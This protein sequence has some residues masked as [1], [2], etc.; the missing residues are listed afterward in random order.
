[1]TRAR[2]E[3]FRVDPNDF[4]ARRTELVRE[5]RARGEKNEAAEVKA[6]RRPTVPVWA[7]NRV[8]SERPDLVQHMVTAAE[9]ARAAQQALLEG[10]PADEFRD[11]LA[12]RRE[13][14]SSV[15]DAANEVVERSSR[16]RDTY[17]RDIDNA[18]NVVVASPELSDALARGE[19]ED[20]SSG[21]D[22]SE[23][24]FGGLTPATTDR[25]A[26]TKESAA[27]PP[28]TTTPPPA[29]PKPRAPSARLVKAREEL[30]EQR[31]ELR[32]AEQAAQAAERVVAAAES[33]VA[34]A[35]RDLERASAQ[36]DHARE[37]VDRMQSRVER[38]EELVQRLDP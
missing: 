10:S 38:S 14:M 28:K 26:R 34:K 6:L 32:A 1:M 2:E 7:L 30:E 16:S 37:H 3:L 11:A 24:L 17:T 33:S 22:G 31:G 36:R 19:L 27:P 35:T 12:R 4:V 29:S 20:V 21:A 23:E 13:A 5:L 25:P 9:T 18:L 8:A 15:S